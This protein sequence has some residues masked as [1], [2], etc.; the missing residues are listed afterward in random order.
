MIPGLL[1]WKHK[2]WYLTHSASH[3]VV[4]THL[5]KDIWNTTPE[6]ACHAYQ[7]GGEYPPYAGVWR[8]PTNDIAW[9]AA[10]M[11][12]AAIHHGTPE[13]PTRPVGYKTL[14]RRGTVKTSH[15]GNHTRHGTWHLRPPQALMPA[16][17]CNAHYSHKAPREHC[18]CGYHAAYSA[19]TLAAQYIGEAEGILVCTPVGTTYWHSNGWRA[20]QY[21]IHAAV[22]GTHWTTP[23]GWDQSIP[24]IRT[25]PAVIPW[26]AYQI[27]REI[28]AMNMIAT[29]ETT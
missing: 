28:A 11:M 2:E 29:G 13:H 16:A 3:I 20:R 15:P 25:D 17:T 18:Q 9:I 6:I 5:A 1:M 7:E 8:P 14:L 21:Q 26:Q 12:T 22:T 23:E 10:S 19:G 24:V 27:A 4:A